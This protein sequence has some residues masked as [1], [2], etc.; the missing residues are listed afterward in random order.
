MRTINREELVGDHYGYKMTAAGELINGE[1]F[2]FSNTY[3]NEN[4]EWVYKPT[5]LF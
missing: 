4:G 1:A 3:Q 2:H 5:R